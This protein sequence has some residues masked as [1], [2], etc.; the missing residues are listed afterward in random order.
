MSL[1]SR[2]REFHG[3]LVHLDRSQSPQL[4]MA[5]QVS[6]YDRPLNRL[7]QFYLKHWS[8][9]LISIEF[10]LNIYFLHHG[11]LHPI[12]YPTYLVQA[13]QIRLGERDYAKI[14]GPTGPLVYPGGHVAI[15]SMFERLFGVRGDP[16][17]PGYLPAQLIFLGLQLVHTC[18][19]FF[20]RTIPL[21]S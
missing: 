6:V 16:D 8:L 9:T 3:V 7:G 21:T 2:L 11:P 5:R 20:E 12:D 14:Y 15:F 10:L 4:P 19:G 18:V 13:R 1:L 17:W